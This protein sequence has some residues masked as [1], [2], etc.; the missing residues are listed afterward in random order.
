METI[1]Q[2]G[3]WYI[4]CFLYSSG[5]YKVEIMIIYIVLDNF[6]FSDFPVLTPISYTTTP[7]NRFELVRCPLRKLFCGPIVDLCLLLLATRFTSVFFDADS[8]NCYLSV[9]LTFLSVAENIKKKRWLKSEC[10]IKQRVGANINFLDHKTHA[11]LT[12]KILSL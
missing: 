2:H 7:S 6:R 12:K 10:H 3:N 1:R 11:N 4:M 9:Y 8:R 5:Y